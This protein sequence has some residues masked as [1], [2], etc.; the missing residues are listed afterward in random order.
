[1]RFP[2]VLVYESDG[3]LAARLREAGPGPAWSLREP[4]RPESCLRLLRR[5]GPAVLVLKVGRDL[6]RELALLQQVTWL[7]PDTATVVVTD[8]D[9]AAL[10]GLAWDLGA[11]YVVSP[12]LSRQL[13]PDLVAGLLRPAAAGP[14]P[15]PEG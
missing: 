7:F 12:P 8:S 6:V 5:G 2:Q 11:S 14:E 3:L 1:M 4:R 15:V 9:E 10:T 13:L